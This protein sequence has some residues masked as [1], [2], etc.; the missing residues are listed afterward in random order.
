MFSGRSQMMKIYSL[1]TLMISLCLVTGLTYFYWSSGLMNGEN[2][3]NLY[4]ASTWVEDLQSTNTV[5]RIERDLNRLNIRRAYKSFESLGTKIKDISSIPNL[6]SRFELE[7]SSF[8]DT[9]KNFENVMG[10]APSNK[11]LRIFKDKLVKFNSF[12]S[13]N[14]WRTLTRMSTRMMSS[15]SQMR[16]SDYIEVSKMTR[17]FMKD[18]KIMKSVTDSSILTTGDKLIINKR[19]GSMKVE[20]EM[21]S[22]KMSYLESLVK[23]T[24][25]FKAQYNI[26]LDDLGP[27]ISIAQLDSSR[28]NNIISMGLIGLSGV[29]LI[30]IMGISFVSKKELNKNKINEENFLVN[31]FKNQMIPP[32]IE[33]SEGSKDFRS[34]MAKN[35]N[36]IQKRMNFGVVFQTSLPFPAIMLDENLK[37]VWGNTLFSDE[38]NINKDQIEEENITWDYI[39][40]FTNLEEN[41]PIMDAVQNDLAG[42]YQIKVKGKSNKAMVP[43]EMYLNPVSHGKS[44]FVMV[45]FYPLKSME[46]T[47]TEQAKS[48]VEPVSYYLDLMLKGNVEKQQF[49]KVQD[50]FFEAGIDSVFDKFQALND[51]TIDQR[52][53]LIQRIEKLDSKIKDYS[54]VIEIIGKFVNDGLMSSKK[55]SKTYSKLKGVI[56]EYGESNRVFS[57]YTESLSLSGQKLVLEFEKVL[58]LNNENMKL[59][60]DGIATKSG[61]EKLN[62]V[63]KKITASAEDT[64]YKVN[65]A[66]DQLMVFSRT[67][68]VEPQK[69]E[70]TTQKIKGEVKTLDQNM[71]QLN[72]AIRA[73]DVL[74]MKQDMLSKDF[75]EK[76]DREELQK[77]FNETLRSMSRDINAINDEHRSLGQQIKDCEESMI[78]NFKVGHEAHKDQL[79][80]FARL[81]IALNA[82]TEPRQNHRPSLNN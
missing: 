9:K 40:R 43:Y 17:S 15:M 35:Y 12:V 36:Y 52:T 72:K 5:E 67:S 78:Q 82:E 26:W 18:I 74:L 33:F 66:L 50:R 69:L 58:E 14:N 41:D 57:D 54:E 71:S 27:E 49:E 55:F 75:S 42:I 30:M 16:N 63:F 60:R 64:K 81:N 56:A 48:I 24:K 34:R 46:Q 28:K 38:W 7:S 80:C 32:G 22:R 2:T 37:L 39:H 44:K 62:D 20:L 10:V 77:Y 31:Y 59:V 29:L 61:L 6:D 47:I 13:K 68:N 73:F 11:I 21:L 1:L 23:S 25:S 65:Q 4:Q 19:L 8:Q 45:Y 3:S 51:K 76:G 70:L 79:N 53:I